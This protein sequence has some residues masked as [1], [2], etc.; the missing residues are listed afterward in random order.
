MTNIW[1]PL[2]SYLIFLTKKNNTIQFT[3]RVWPHNC[4]S[5][6]FLFSQSFQ[7]DFRPSKHTTHN[8]T[9]SGEQ[10]IIQMKH[11]H[12]TGSGYNIYVDCENA[13]TMNK[14]WSHSYLLRSQTHIFM[15]RFND[16]SGSDCKVYV[17]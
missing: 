9:C 13:E 3:L 7:I 14:L 15:E 5:L 17:R 10:Y 4:E 11:Q 6:L 1:F 2:A 12:P 16:N 8:V